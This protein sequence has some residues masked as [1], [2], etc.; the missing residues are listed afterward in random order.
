MSRGA[1]LDHVN[2]ANPDSCDHPTSGDPGW[3]LRWSSVDER[4]RRILESLTSLGDGLVVSRGATEVFHRGA[5]P[6]VRSPGVFD[7]GE[8]PSLVEG[9]VWTT[10][11]GVS[12]PEGATEDWSLDM[13]SGVLHHRIRGGDAGADPEAGPGAGHWLESIRAV[14]SVRPGVCLLRATLA[15]QPSDVTAPLT[16]PVRPGRRDRPTALSR[17]THTADSVWGSSW[18]SQ[19]ALAGAATQSIVPVDGRRPGV[20]VVRLV[21][22]RT[23]PTPKIAEQRARHALGEARETGFDA[24][25]DEHQRAWRRRWEAADIAI[26]GQPDL[27]REVRFALFH[28]MCGCPVATGNR[29]SA[30]AECALG[31]R[32]ATGP[33]YHGHVFWD[34]DVFVQPALAAFLPEAARATL[35]YRHNRLDAARRLAAQHGHRGAR[36]PWESAHSGVDVTPRWAPDLHGGR[37]PILTGEM[38]EHITADVA[39]A[40]THYTD[41]TSD[42]EFAG[43]IAP[44]LVVETAR[45]WASRIESDAD[46]T[47]HIR[48]VIGPDEYHEDVDDNAY[49]NLMARWNL[50]RGAD[51]LESRPHL[52]EADEIDR[53]RRLAGNLSTGHRPG[54]GGY[55]QFTGWSELEDVPVATLG[56]PP[57][58]ADLLL[59]HEHISRTRILKQADVLMAHHLIPSEMAPGSLEADLDRYLPYTAHGSSLSPAVH[60]SLLARA[61]RT[62]EALGLLTTAARLDLDDITGTTSGGLHTAT[63]G[64]LLQALLTGFLGVEPR[65]T[66]LGVDPRVP[67]EWRSLSVRFRFRTRHLVLTATDT[68]LTT[69]LLRGDP[70]EITVGANPRPDGRFTLSPGRVQE[71][72]WVDGTWEM[73]R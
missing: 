67:A 25:L 59:G 50:R 42:G 47:G 6:G 26:G 3:V 31:A 73:R 70:L 51:A 63:M 53:W 9:P 49:T 45:Y 19:G 32:G 65:G 14:S 41:W 54:W 33:A 55:E 16:G 29:A 71:L 44:E 1:P 64:G 43:R 22:Y 40:A 8:V 69:E 21:A 2:G 38:E 20:E 61:G 28:L 11:T 57:L 5:R 52:G 68:R 13:S 7:D 39:W 34:T 23:G 37:I 66:G 72:E 58:A 48:H 24:L 18:G 46:G 36:F 62:A 27:T 12:P 4:R 60:A 10:L 17:L 35:L 15:V 56:R 30:P